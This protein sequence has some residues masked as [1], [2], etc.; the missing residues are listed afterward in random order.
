[1]LYSAK[2]GEFNNIIKSI[3]ETIRGVNNFLI[4]RASINMLF[5]SPFIYLTV[6]KIFKKFFKILTAKFNCLHNYGFL[7]KDAH[8]Q[9]RC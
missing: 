9:G 6:K 7:N 8:F 5:E 3:I 4:F 1:M 2:V